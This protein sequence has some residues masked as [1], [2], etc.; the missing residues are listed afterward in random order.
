MK[1]TRYNIKPKKNN[2]NNFLFCLAITLLIALLLGTFVAKVIL[3]NSGNFGFETPSDEGQVVGEPSKNNRDGDVSKGDNP[4]AGEVSISSYDFYILQ[5][6]VFKVK[7]NAS[8]LMS[9]LDGIGTPFIGEEGELSKV[10]FGIYSSG[11]IEG[12]V[13]LL[14]EK[15]VNNTRVTINIPLEDGS[16]TQLCEIIEG[17]LQIVNKASDSGVKSINTADLKKWTL[18]LNVIEPTMKEYSSVT[19]MKEYINTLPDQVD[20]SKI[21]DIYKFVYGKLIKFKK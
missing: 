12:G 5:C 14:K 20:K 4:T 9:K 3:K 21:Q 1:Y 11:N 15:S 10:C 2:G 17:L 16:T 19:E 6:G 7:E 13:G 8:E 18:E